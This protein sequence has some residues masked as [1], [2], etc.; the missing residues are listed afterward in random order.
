MFAREVLTGHG[1]CRYYVKG[2]AF[3]ASK[4]IGRVTTPAHWNDIGA[5]H[6]ALFI[7]FYFLWDAE[8]KCVLRSE[9]HGRRK[10]TQLNL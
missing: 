7:L 6:Y 2:K 10:V 1:Q 8:L 9:G 3:L 5:V 4:H